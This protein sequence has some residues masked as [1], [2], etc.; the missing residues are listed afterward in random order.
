L[1][2][3]AGAS[4]CLDNLTIYNIPVAKDGIIGEEENEEGIEE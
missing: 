4:V 2:S 3:D 1:P